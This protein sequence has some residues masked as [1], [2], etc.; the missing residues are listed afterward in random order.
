MQPGVTETEEERLSALYSFRIL[1]TATE[2]DFDDI[3]ELAAAICDM[4]ISLI[5]FVDKDRQWFKSVKG[6]GLRE[7]DIASSFCKYTVASKEV[8]VVEDARKDLRFA[9]N[10]LVTGQPNI[11]FYMGVPLLSEEGYALGSLCI[12][13]QQPR[14]LSDYQKQS[15]KT[16]ARQTMDKLE[17]RK[18]LF[19]L[20]DAKSEIVKLKDERYIKEN[21][22]REVIEHAPMAMALHVG[23][24]M[25]IR[26]ANSRMLQAW[27]KDGEVF[28]LPFADALPELRELDFPATMREVYDSGIPYRNED[29][30]MS[31]EYQGEI[32]EFYYTYA[33]T[34]LKTPEGKV[35]GLLNTALDVTEIVQSRLTVERAEEQLRLAVDSAELGT[36]HLDLKTNQLSLSPRSM[37]MF[38][39]ET[40]E[41]VSLEAAIGRIEEHYRGLVNSSIQAAIE[42]NQPYDVEYPILSSDTKRCWVR[43][44][45]KA[46]M[47]N[48]HGPTMFSGTLLDITERKEEDRRKNDFIGIVSHE[49]RTPITS[50]S[51]YAQVLQRKAQSLAEPAMAD[52]AR[53]TK[54]QADR[55]TKLINGFLDIARIGEGKIRL[56]RSAFDMAELVKEAEDES[57]TTITSHEVVFKP[58]EFTPVEADQDKIRQ[59]LINLINNAVKYSPPRSRIQVACVTEGN[60]AQVSVKDEGIGVPLKDHDRIFER[61]YRV[62]NEQMKT[63]KG[64]G[65]GLF[66]CKEIIELHG[67]QIGVESIPGQGSIFWFT[68]PVIIQ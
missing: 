54:Q 10:P 17:L 63:V 60:H 57:L 25:T 53:K 4:P 42:E 44:T 28:G 6:I 48:E 22:A 21:E 35:W 64:F 31:Y 43:A 39:F 65:I 16:L 11:V 59:V 34:P 9:N 14:Q 20:Q 2:Q 41:E 5:S 29:A 15:L 45:G 62:E 19:E 40:T 30:R 33:F 26:F 67:G 23:R 1:D 13:D 7:T 8:F 58:V 18:K 47:V 51:G 52:I 49:L 61:F 24:D 38:G 3:A 56:E 27:D 55:M 68:L 66:I 46:Y 32:R 37:E 12:I 36:W 50:I